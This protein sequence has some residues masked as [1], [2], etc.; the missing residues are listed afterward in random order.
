M[1]FKPPRKK[2]RHRV[3]IEIRGPKDKKKFNA[4][5][6]DLLKCLRRHG[7]KVAHKELII[8]RRG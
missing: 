4:Y 8:R 3:V 1:G 5:K 6:R 7:A 2:E